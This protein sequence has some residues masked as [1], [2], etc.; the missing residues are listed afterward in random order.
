MKPAIKSA[1]VAIALS[2]ALAPSAFARSPHGW[3]GNTSRSFGPNGGLTLGA[4]RSISGNTAN[5][6]VTATGPNGR[7]LQNKWSSSYGNNTGNFTHSLT[8]GNGN[9]FA[10]NL[11][12]TKNGNGSATVTD[13]RSGPWGGGTSSQTYQRPQ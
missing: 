8:T 2:L 4:Q 13:T 10:N 3:T 9:T 7:L 12:V 5:S 1:A 6:S 11:S